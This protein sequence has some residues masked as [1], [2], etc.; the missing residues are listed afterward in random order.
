M[1]DDDTGGFT[2]IAPAGVAT[3][4]TAAQATPQDDTGGF[5][6]IHDPSENPWYEKFAHGFEGPMIGA[7][8]LGA[9]IN[10][11]TGMG[12]SMLSVR[13]TGEQPTGMAFSPESPEMLEKDLQRSEER[14][15]EYQ[16]RGDPHFSVW[17]TIGNLASPLNYA[18]GGAAPGAGLA[19]RIAAGA[20]AGLGS[21]IFQPEHGL[22]SVALGTAAGAAGSAIA[23]PLANAIVGGSTGAIDKFIKDNF[24][25]AIKPT[26]SGRSTFKQDES[27]VGKMQQAIGAIVEN[28]DKLSLK[29]EYGVVLDPGARPETLQQFSQAID[30]T[31]KEVFARYDAM[32]KAAGTSVTVDLSPIV[33]ELGKI[34]QSNVLND[35][36]PET[37]KAADAIAETLKER[38]SYTT[39]EA[40]EAIQ[41]LNSDL[42]AYY[43]NPN[44]DTASRAGVSAIV[45]SGLR[46]S[47]DKSV[48][49]AV[50][51]GYQELK[52]QYGALRAIEKDVVKRAIRVG[53]LEKG[54]GLIGSFGDIVSAEEVIR[55]LLT[56]NPAAVATGAGIRA[57]TGFNRY[58]KSPNRAVKR[59]F[60]AAERRQGMPEA[61]S[62]PRAA[63]GEVARRVAPVAG[64]VTAEEATP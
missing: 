63:L 20:Y 25:R 3:P 11:R 30:Q 1:A 29:D 50:G 39:V 61:P 4:S 22:G 13:H 36:H 24:S 45:A 52:N 26:V 59:L 48:S 5:E 47:L 34:S 27:Y 64:A 9:Q 42:D 51:P 21:S 54:R 40:Q 7:D 38:G 17:E 2:K 16:A 43:K 35:L 8:L 31:K 6:K 37:V 32:A 14:K 19:A 56:F 60:E 41:H 23:E 12:Q 44:F 62:A 46:Q 53:T 15:R 28:K 49:M 58:L 55:G 33:K 10:K 18:L 57:F